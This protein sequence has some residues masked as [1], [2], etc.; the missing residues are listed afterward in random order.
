MLTKNVENDE[1]NQYKNLVIVLIKSESRISLLL[2][3]KYALHIS[4][5]NKIIEVE[6][7]TSTNSFT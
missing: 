3:L 1:N 5:V 2:A 7:K 6:S 4:S